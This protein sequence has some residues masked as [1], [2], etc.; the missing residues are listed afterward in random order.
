MTSG[1]VY[2]HLTPVKVWER[3]RAKA[4]YL[5]EAYDADGFIHCT[6][7]DDLVVAVGNRYYRDDPRP[8]V[9][10]DIDPVRLNSEVRFEDPDAVYPHIY[11][12]L[13]TSAVTGLCQ[14]VR[15]ETGTFIRLGQ[16]RDN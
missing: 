15:D 2:L 9:V 7:G 14:I 12:P 8:Y 10:L 16:S 3:Q 1:I 6:L 13:D 4:T 5:P 11:G